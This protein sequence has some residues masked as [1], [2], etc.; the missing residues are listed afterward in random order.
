MEKY[1]K[2]C[3][4]ITAFEQINL[5]EENIKRIRTQYKILNNNDIVI[6]STSD[7]DVGFERLENEYSNVHFIDFPNA[8][9]N[10]NSSIRNRN[11]PCGN[12]ISW[13]HEFLPM[14][15]LLSFQ[16]GIQYSWDI[17]FNKILHLHSDTY[18]KPEAENKLIS[19]I[20]QLDYCL[21]VADTS[22]EEELNA[23]ILKTLPP[24]LHLH[25]EGLLLNLDGCYKCGYGF[26]F[27][28]IFRKDS[29]FISHNYSCIAALLSQ[30]LIYCLT[31]KNITKYDDQLP[32]EYH[33]NVYLRENRPYHSGSNGFLSGLVNLSGEQSDGR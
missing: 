33:K 1:N 4:I 6:V 23:K 31:G 8:P 26:T 16:K 12:Y 32:N 3:Y 2:F 13:R 21:M 15:I 20:N 24:T 30:Y 17:G 19:Y 18:F 14:R 22:I 29:N 10:K 9:G 5:V 27:G 25:P 11:N 28:N 7:R